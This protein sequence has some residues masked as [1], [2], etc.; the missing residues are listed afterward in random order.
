MFIRKFEK[1]SFRLDRKIN[2]GI[3]FIYLSLICNFAR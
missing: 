2:I 3:Y 1:M